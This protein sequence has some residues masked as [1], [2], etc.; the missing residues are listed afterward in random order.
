MSSIGLGKTMTEAFS[1]LRIEQGT[2]SMRAKEVIRL[3]E[4]LKAKEEDADDL[5]VTTEMQEFCE[6]REA[7]FDAIRDWYKRSGEQIAD[8]PDS[9]TE[10]RI[11]RVHVFFNRIREK[12][13][14][15]RPLGLEE[16][17]SETDK[18]WLNAKVENFPESVVPAARF[19]AHKQEGWKARLRSGASSALEGWSSKDVNAGG[20]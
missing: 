12:L 19:L 18:I 13:R 2:I 8:H 6:V 16:K 14:E 10:D 17:E 1:D 5:E 7:L 9:R 11:R 15:T 20:G 4:E 3:F